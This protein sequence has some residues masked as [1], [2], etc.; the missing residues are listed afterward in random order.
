MFQVIGSHDASTVFAD[1]NGSADS[2]GVWY[3]REDFAMGGQG[4]L[5]PRLFDQWLRELNGSMAREGRSVI[6]LPVLSISCPAV[7]HLSRVAVL[8]HVFPPTTSS[9][10]I[11]MTPWPVGRSLTVVKCRLNATMH[12][13]MTLPFRSG[14]AHNLKQPLTPALSGFGSD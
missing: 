5:S 1:A 12:H 8:Y 11:W 2:F 6:V 7:R 3:E 14:L 4:G 13:P 10:C 9:I